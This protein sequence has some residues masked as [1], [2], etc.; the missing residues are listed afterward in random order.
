M[1]R[2]SSQMRYDVL[3]TFGHQYLALFIIIISTASA[4]PSRLS[5]SASADRKRTAAAESDEFG[6]VG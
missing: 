3:V 1:C 5:E 6:K 4:H 2:T